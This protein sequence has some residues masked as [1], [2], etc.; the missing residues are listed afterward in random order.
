M[1]T[2]QIYKLAIQMGIKADLRGEQKVKKYLE[3]FK[4]NYEKIS[5][6]EK[7]EFDVEKLIN[8][9]SD[10]RILVDNK[11]KNIKK[12]FVGIDM[13][14]TELLL[15]EKFNADLVIAHHP[16]GKALADLASVID[17]QAEVLANNGVP[18][19]IA[20][21]LIKTR[22]SEVSRNLSP[23]NHN[24]SVDIAKILKLDFICVHTP[25]D[26]LAANFLVKTIE[27][28]KPETLNEVLDMLK[29]IPEF[30]EAINYNAGPKIFVGYPE[31]S[32]GKIVVSEFTGGTNG[33]KEI[34]EKMAQAGIGTIISMHM[35]EDYRKEAE[36]YHINVIVAGHIASDSL[37][38]NLF[39]DELEK[40][41]MDIVA[42]SGLIRVKRIK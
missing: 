23:I 22:I 3:R 29:K 9:Y 30:K 1:T 6:E 36:K 4:K 27:K 26:N 39:L 32:C 17:L 40:T 2:Q 20:E 33:S 42:I 12:I 13:K 31:A 34:Y 18:I 28:E 35:N 10:T 14:G 5:H 7:K 11:K 16:E 25:A 38:I 24:R 8:P 41:N 37:G 15:A 21:S 19:N